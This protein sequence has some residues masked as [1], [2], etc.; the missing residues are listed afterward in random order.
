[1]F[2]FLKGILSA[3]KIASEIVTGGVR[4]LDALV[5]TEEEKAKMSQKTFETW[6]EVQKAI[7]GES[8][9]RSVTRRILACMIMGT[10]LGFMVA[11]GGLFYWFPEWSA[12]MLSLAKQ[13]ST[14]AIAVGVFYFGT[15][16]IG[17]YLKK[18]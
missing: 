3:P 16:G 2:G 7:A 10:F 9:V 12:Y 18:K 5:F 1:M 17:Q 13:L 14:L 15:Y 11:G 8:T 6:L 4:A